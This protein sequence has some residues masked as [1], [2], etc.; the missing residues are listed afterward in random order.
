MGVC[1]KGYST[2][3]LIGVKGDEVLIK[4]NIV[5]TQDLIA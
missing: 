1:V 5:R 2:V 4:G 3:T